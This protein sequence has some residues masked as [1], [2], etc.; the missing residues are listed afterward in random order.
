MKSLPM[1]PTDPLFIYEFEG[2]LPD[3]TFD[4][5]ADFL[6][7]WR[8]GEQTFLFFSTSQEASLPL[9]L[10]DHPELVWVRSHQLSYQDWQGGQWA[11]GLSVGKLRFV[12]PWKPASDPAVP[13]VIRMDPGV[14]FGSGQH[15]T[16]RDS[17]QA[18]LWVYDRDC[19]KKV[20]D[21]G[22]GSGIL[23]LASAKLGA[24]LILACDWNPACVRTAERNVALNHLESLITVKEGRAEEFIR[25]SADLLLANLHFAVLRDLI[26]EKAFYEK[27][28]VILSGLLRS[29]YGQI[30]DRL[31]LSGFNLLKEWESDQTWFTLV[32]R[33]RGSL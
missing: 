8:E 30:K 31:S 2:V 5:Q 21:L 15:P 3:E 18:L 1:K 24:Q 29:E 20:L 7:H 19:P 33:N 11:E 6:A 12:P 10:K 13:L 22:T 27:S 16:T 26:A 17:L 32:G 4:F 25:E 9:F 14:V 28:W 23:G